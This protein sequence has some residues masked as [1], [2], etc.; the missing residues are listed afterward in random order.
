MTRA[1]NKGPL[2]QLAPGSLQL[3]AAAAD[4]LPLGPADFIQTINTSLAP[5]IAS[6]GGNRLI[7]AAAS[8]TG[9][10]CDIGVKLRLDTPL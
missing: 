5:I 10:E 4:W 2:L 3:V 1:R 6:I 8:L 7:I 9:A